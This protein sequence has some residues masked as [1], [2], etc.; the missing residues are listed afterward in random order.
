MDRKDETVDGLL[1]VE[2]DKVQ[3]YAL[4]GEAK[5]FIGERTLRI[6]TS[7]VDDDDIYFIIMGSLSIPLNAMVPCLKVGKGIYVFPTDK[8]TYGIHLPS[9]CPE[10]VIDAIELV[11]EENTLYKQAEFEIVTVDS[12]KGSPPPEEQKGEKKEDVQPVGEVTPEPGAPK[13]LLPKVVVTAPVALPGKDQ[14]EVESKS[15][16]VAVKV[17]GAPV[18]AMAPV[19]IAEKLPMEQTT[20][21]KTHTE[22]KIVTSEKSTEVKSTPPPTT[23][24]STTTTTTVV[25]QEIS[26]TFVEKKEEEKKEPKTDR[27]VSYSYRLAEGIQY[28]GDKLVDGVAS[29]GQALGK[30][31]HRGADF[32]VSRTT[33]SQSNLQIS[34]SSKKRIERAKMASGAA[35][36]VST[37]I[38]LCNGHC[39]STIASSQLKCE[40]NRL[41]QK[42][43]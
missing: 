11:L 16:M 40:T 8:C 7:M 18:V 31:V 15:A 41:W 17:R 25:P 19:K 29:G 27:V 32:I 4:N 23:T 33:P 3:L 42:D 12:P 37:V 1:V 14:K 6:L 34:E 10:E 39:V 30:A 9:E 2:L 21:V 24:P 26:L 20:T 38:S 5:T 36:K 13:G 22:V 35:V 43:F 28:G